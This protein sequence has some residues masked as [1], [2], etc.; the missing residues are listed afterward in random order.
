MRLQKIVD[1]IDTETRERLERSDGYQMAQ[2]QRFDENESVF[3][4]RELEHI[5]SRTFDIKFK[6]LKQRELLP[7]SFE[8]GPGAKSI[9]Y[10][11]F[12]QHGVAKI[13]SN[14]ADD[15]PMA[16]ISGKEF[17]SP[18]KTL[19]MA[20]GWTIDE[21]RSAVMAGRSLTD[22]KARATRRGHMETE[23]K[24]A[25]FG[26]AACDLPGFLTNPNVISVT[27]PNDGT[28][29]STKFED[30][31]PDQVLRDLN[32]MATAIHDT[33]KAVEAPDT[34]LLP[35]AQFNLIFV[36]PRSIHSDMSIGRWFLENSPHVENVDWLDELR[37]AGAGGVDVMAAY[38]RDPEKLQ[39]E[40][41]SDYET[42]P[43]QIKNL[44]FKV[45]TMQKI[46]GTII[47]YP[48]SVALGEG[49]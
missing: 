35:I 8:A 44:S 27:I 23:S 19:A 43:V 17:T 33:S 9:T 42:L 36:T 37:G 10:R 13:V 39:L 41:P 25:W 12:T 2:Q 24:I 32:S 30:K 40:I 4:A 28:G 29:S 14:Y 38:H 1:S 15:L 22:R 31:T 34:L 21:V 3:F 16:E 5:K 48:L 49:V 46:G 20:Y 7:T 47:E 45:P 11:Q 6:R 18:V 26:D